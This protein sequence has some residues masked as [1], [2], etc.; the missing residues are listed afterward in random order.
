MAGQ[1]VWGLSNHGLTIMSRIT[2]TM[3]WGRMAFP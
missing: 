3:N 1:E 2:G